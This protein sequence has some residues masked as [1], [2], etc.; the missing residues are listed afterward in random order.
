M[1]D[2]TT[3][4]P[5]SAS[6][7]R[8]LARF[9]VD[10]TLAR[11][12]AWVLG[13]IGVSGAVTIGAFLFLQGTTAFFPVVTLLVVA[14]AYNIVLAY[15]LHLNRVAQTFVLGVFLDNLTLLVGWLI[16]TF[17]VA[18]TK[19]TNDLWLILFPI[20]IFGVVRIGWMLGSLY[21]AFWLAWMSW[22][23]LTFYDWESYDVQQLPIRIV[24]LGVTAVLVIR[25]TS[26]LNREKRLERAR[27]REL[28]RVEDIKSRLLLTISHELQSPI[29]AAKGA[30]GLIANGNATEAQERR[31]MQAL[32]SGVERLE[33]I[34]RDALEYARLEDVTLS[35]TQRPI[36]VAKTLR[37][38]LDLLGPGISAKRQKLTTVFPD[39]PPLFHIDQLH[40]ER[41]LINL[42]TNA[43]TFTPPEGTITVTLQTNDQRLIC[44]VSDSGI[45]I[46]EE[47]LE[48]IFD[49]HYRGD[50]ADRREQPG[51]G[52]GLPTVKKLVER[53]DGTIRVDST[54]GK[55]T[56]VVVELPSHSERMNS[57]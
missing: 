56:M 8:T 51:L 49:E 17:A 26:V 21:T 20:V 23:F 34:T 24:F 16:V 9:G 53:Y 10:T 28:E 31:A 38:T 7:D 18:G 57:R 41:I 35:E 54:P 47:N 14:L 39:E 27:I 43:N 15:F 48:L 40:W 25:L 44:E 30:L 50:K 45:G 42:M 29:T 19:E 52:L 12:R 6:L 36:D 55:G 4:L 11:E 32:Q 2:M 3:P 1:E 37:E 22:S 5:S 33:S 46:S 13:R